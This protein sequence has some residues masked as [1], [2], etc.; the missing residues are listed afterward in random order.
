MRAEGHAGSAVH[1]LDRLSFFSERYGSYQACFLALAA[2][3]AEIFV[4]NHTTIRFSLQG[5]RR[6][7]SNAGRI[8]AAAA[9]DN[10]KVALNS[11]LRLYLNGAI[12]QRGLAGVNAAA[13]KH[14]SQAADAALRMGHLEATALPGLRWR[15]RLYPGRL[16]GGPSLCFFDLFCS[17]ALSHIMIYS[18][19][20]WLCYS[21][22]FEME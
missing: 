14:A 5:S 9:D 11:S 8:L 20:E 12:L 15:G 21:F 19:Q 22:R 16:K 18:P 13:C 7:G 4:E 2:S 17:L 10:A 3:S 6:T 1:A